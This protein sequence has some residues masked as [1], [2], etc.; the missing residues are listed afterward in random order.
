MPWGYYAYVI[1]DN[2]HVA[3]RIEINCGDDDEA[4]RCAKRLVDGHEIELWQETRQVATFTPKSE[5]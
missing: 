5:Q 4:I 3:N 1:D 2:G